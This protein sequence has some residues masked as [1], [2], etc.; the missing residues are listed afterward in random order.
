MP[1][2]ITIDSKRTRT[3][4]SIRKIYLA[5]WGKW[6]RGTDDKVER[7]N[8]EA[9]AWHKK[10]HLSGAERCHLPCR[11]WRLHTVTKSNTIDDFKPEE[12]AALTKC[13]LEQAM[14]HAL[15]EFVTICLRPIIAVANEASGA[16][17]D[18]A[19][20]RYGE[21]IP[22]GGYVASWLSHRISGWHITQ[23]VDCFETVDKYTSVPE[24]PR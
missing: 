18:F 4:S 14:Q 19:I 12:R 2:V 21:L 13:D 11:C 6:V 24:I 22:E 7:R 17:N 3:N 16:A 1:I 5:V 23:Q 20:V 15:H 10:Y 8:N 9:T